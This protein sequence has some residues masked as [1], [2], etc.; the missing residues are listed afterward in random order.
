M[1]TAFFGSLKDNTDDEL[2]PEVDQDQNQKAPDEDIENGKNISPIEAKQTQIEEKKF[3]LRMKKVQ[4][5][6]ANLRWKDTKQQLLKSN[7]PD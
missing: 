3:K 7:D 2:E 5:E 1:K 4:K 6:A